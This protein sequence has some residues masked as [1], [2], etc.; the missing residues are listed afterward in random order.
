MID[1]AIHPLLNNLL[2]DLNRSL[3]Q[4]THEAWPWAADEASRKARETLDQLAGR[5]Q[6]SVEQLSAFLAARGQTLPPSVYPDD[7][8]NLNYVSVRYL[9]KQILVN[10]EAIVEVCESA[11]AAT[12]HDPEAAPLI[13]QIRDSER[14]I[15]AALNQL[16]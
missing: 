1:T 9:L 3:L 5:Q 10:E 13:S 15:L 8:T 7:Y 12:A 4:Y 11:A 14:E 2:V 16:F 6:L